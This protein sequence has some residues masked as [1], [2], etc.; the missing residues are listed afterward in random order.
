MTDADAW[1]FAPSLLVK[2]GK[3]DIDKQFNVRHEKKWK[4]DFETKSK[5][6]KHFFQIFF[7][8]GIGLRGV[9]RFMGMR[10]RARGVLRTNG[11]CVAL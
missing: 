9:A 10:E 2:W 5:R 4:K 8:G 11:L 3:E 6:G 1:R 7:W